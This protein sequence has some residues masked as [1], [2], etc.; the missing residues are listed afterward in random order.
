MTANQPL[1]EA[2]TLSKSFP[3]P[4]TGLLRSA[5]PAVHAVREVSLQVVAGRTLGIVGE[6]GCGKSTFAR[7]LTRLLSPSAGSVWF[8]GHDVTN[9]EG[10]DMA[11]FR[12]NVQMVFQD[13]MG[14]LNPRQTVSQILRTPR[15]YLPDSANAPTDEELLRRVGLPETAAMQHPHEFSGGQRQ[16]IGI[17]RAL[18]AQPRVIVADEPVSALD[19]SIQAQILNL[20]LELQEGMGLAYVLISHDLAV[21]RRMADTVAVMYLGRVV[22]QGHADGVLSQPIHPYSQALAAAVLRPDPAVRRRTA[23]S[24]SETAVTPPPTGCAYRT[25]CPLAHGRCAVEE[26]VLRSIGADERLVACHV[27]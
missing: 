21:V 16:R 25:R 14:S 9:A 2:R 5:G 20:L 4:R 7:L 26:P 22:E 19:V 23:P 12:A 1:L 13:P 24:R 3:G 18:V 6:S 11:H 8:E 17:A 10:G 27:V 15:R